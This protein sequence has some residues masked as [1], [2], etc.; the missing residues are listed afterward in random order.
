MRGSHFLAMVFVIATTAPCVA[1]EDVID[2]PT[3]IKQIE[4]LGGHVVDGRPRGMTVNIE[5]APTATIP[6]WAIV[7]PLCVLAAYLLLTKPRSTK[8][9][10]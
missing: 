10:T 9:E 8:S 1:A 2:E 6:Y 4:L 5:P 3:A 7:V